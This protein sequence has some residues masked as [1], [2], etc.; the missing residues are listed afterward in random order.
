MAM[1]LFGYPRRFINLMRPPISATV[2]LVFLILNALVWLGFGLLIALDLHPALPDQPFIQ[3]IMAILALGIAGIMVGLFVFLRKGNQIAYFLTVGL[4]A[5]IALL[6]VFDEFGAADL[7]V[8]IVDL[9]PLILL[10]KD[11]SWFLV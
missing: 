8:L 4:L 3:T 11:R 2:A 1:V 6:T 10:I 7:V 5:G 9:V